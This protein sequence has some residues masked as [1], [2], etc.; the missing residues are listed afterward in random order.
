MASFGIEWETNALMLDMPEGK[1]EKRPIIKNDKWSIT[2]EG[3]RFYQIRD[4]KKERPENDEDCQYNLEVQIGPVISNNYGSFD[5]RGVMDSCNH[6]FKNIWSKI[7]DKKHIVIDGKEYPVLSYSIGNTAE[8]R[9]ED[10]KLSMPG[11][12]NNTEGN[13]WGY[14]KSLNNIYGKAQFTIGLK[15]KDVFAVFRRIVKL[16]VDCSEDETKCSTIL[17]RGHLYFII[18]AYFDTY[19]ECLELNRP[20]SPELLSFIMLVN[21]SLYV[22]KIPWKKYFKALF[23]IKPRTN[24]ACIYNL[25]SNDDKDTFDEWVEKCIFERMTDKLE[26]NKSVEDMDSEIVEKIN[27]E[28]SSLKKWFDDIKN[29]TQKCY[30]IANSE[31]V[32][33][34]ELVTSDNK[35]IIETSRKVPCALYPGYKKFSKVDFEDGKIVHTIWGQDL[36]EWSAGPNGEIYLEFRS[37]ETI[38]SLISKEVNDSFTKI[39]GRSSIGLYNQLGLTTIAGVFVK[40][41]LNPIFEAKERK[42]IRRNKVN[43]E[44]FNATIKKFEVDRL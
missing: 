1:R 6:F 42:M 10:C 20:I 34:Y 44:P 5:Y 30:L 25:L 36:Q 12:L 26:E 40:H 11:T 33:K 39:E 27:E 24:F 22:N 23:L 43:L 3:I 14:I 7:L 17:R 35:E 28:I 31:A 21:Y 32:G 9:F 8:E 2:L 37:V 13:E 29:P 41:F 16:Y 38:Y 15:L 18:N 4:G 19:E